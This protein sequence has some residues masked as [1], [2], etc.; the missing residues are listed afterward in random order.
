MS[1]RDEAWLFWLSH[2]KSI[3][4]VSSKFASES[5]LDIDDFKQ[6]L[7]LRLVSKHETYDQT[8]C[9]PVSWLWWQAKAVRKSLLQKRAKHFVGLSEDVAITNSVTGDSGCGQNRIEAIVSVRAIRALATQSQWRAVTAKT[10]GFT[11]NETQKVLG[12][13]PATAR[14]RVTRLARRLEG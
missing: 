6:E 3:Q 10:A 13:H 2:T 5:R 12:C 9:K 14:R 8:R 11:E 1:I 7:V 4:R